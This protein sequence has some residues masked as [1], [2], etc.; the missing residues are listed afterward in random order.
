M[1]RPNGVRT[2]TTGYFDT[3]VG[4]LEARQRSRQL[5]A[6]GDTRFSLSARR[7]PRTSL[8]PL[9]ASSFA[10]ASPIPEDAP[11]IITTLFLIMVVW[12]VVN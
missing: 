9:L 5:N 7:A 4:L 1:P 10:V 11:V 8:V 3:K 12:S 2:T 6:A